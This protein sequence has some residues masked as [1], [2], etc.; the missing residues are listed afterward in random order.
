MRLNNVIPKSVLD[1]WRLQGPGEGFGSGLINDTYFVD[2]KYV[3]QRLN[4]RV[5]T[6]PP[7]LMRNL[8]KVVKQ[9]SGVVAEFR[10]GMNGEYFFV[11]SENET[12]RLSTYYESRTFDELPIELAESAGAAFGHFLHCLS[13]VQQELE[14]AIRGF[15]DLSNYLKILDE[16]RC[17]DVADEEL[18]FVDSR[19]KRAELFDVGRQIIH[20]DCKVNNL[21]FHPDRSRVIRIVDLDTLMWG[22]PAWDFGDLV[23]S[24][25]THANSR[26]GMESNH[27]DRL[28]KL[29]R[30]FFANFARERNGDLRIAAF[31]SAP[32]HM[33]FMLGVRFLAD[34]FDGD[35]Y[36]KV[37]TPGENLERARGQFALA[38]QFDGLE[39]ILES[40][41]YDS[42]VSSNASGEHSSRLTQ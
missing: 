21:L 36:F 39:A 30:G 26:E 1:N 2:G 3:L 24:S 38:K 35:R 10:A 25:F 33:S 6:D 29:C 16:A 32:A 28:T 14:P 20:G 37:D 13:G 41:I 7:A 31:A 34:H 5:F 18:L 12:W 11:D 19:P 40:L 42:L 15:H 23:R 9:L 8:Q 4:S 27:V 22:H 17:A